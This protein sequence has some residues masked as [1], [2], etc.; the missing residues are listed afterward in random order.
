MTSLQANL[1]Y[2]NGGWK[3][4]FDPKK[5]LKKLRNFLKKDWTVSMTDYLDD[6]LVTFLKTKTQLQAIDEL[7]ESLDL[8]HQLKDKARFHQAIL[9]R[10]NIVSTGIGLGVAIPHA[11]LP[12]YEQFFIA[13][14][15][16]EEGGIEWNSLDNAPVHLIFMIGGPDNKQT[17]YLNILSR[18]TMAIKDVDRRKALLKATS[19]QQVID[20]FKGC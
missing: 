12:E 20:L 2:T 16:Q 3:G 5:L 7:I 15:L 18:L 8:A 9:D 1:Q 19:A 17:E 14:G 11:K 10:E 13:I 6:R 4:M